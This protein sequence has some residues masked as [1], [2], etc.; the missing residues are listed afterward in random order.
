MVIGSA[1]QSGPGTSGHIADI[2][3]R[4]I[5]YFSP[6]CPHC[7]RLLPIWQTLY[8]FY[9]TS[10]PIQSVSF[11]ADIASPHSPFHVFYDFHF[12]RMNCQAFGDTCE[13]QKINGY[14]T[15]RLY[16]NGE[17]MQEYEGPHSIEGLSHFVEEKLEQIKPGSRP[18]EGVNLPTPG[19]SGVDRSLK[20]DKPL[21]KHND[22]HAGVA[23]GQK[24]NNQ[25]AAL[26]GGEDPPQSHVTT[27]D[28]GK[29]GNRKHSKPPPNP[30][31]T[32]LQL[33]AESFQRLL[34]MTQDAWFVKFYVPW[35]THCQAL[36]PI[37]DEVAKEMKGQLNI[38][39]VNCD[40]ESRLC[41]DA[42]VQAYPT[43]HY[44]RGDERVEYDGYR[45]LGDLL[46]FAQKA[47]DSD[48]K[49][50]DAS[51]FKAMEEDEEVIFLYFFD[52]A[53]TSEDFRAIER[54][55]LNLAGRA[56]IFKTDSE[57]LAQRFRISTWPRL[58]VSRD[59]K[60]TY[61]TALSPSDM[62]NY[63]QIFE[64]MKSVWLPLVPELSV[65]NA[66]DVFSD[67]FV[68]L[69]L[70]SRQRPDEFAASKRELKEAAVEWMDKQTHDFQLERQQ[71]R[72]DKQL[73][74]EEAEDRN[75]QRAVRQVKSQR[76]SITE[77]GFRKPVAF[78]WIDTDFWGRWLH[79]TYGFDAAEGERVIIN[80][81]EV[82]HARTSS[83]SPP[84]ARG[85][86][87]ARL[88]T[89]E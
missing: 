68:V 56:K 25:V 34:T 88:L 30:L 41:K 2:R 63:R 44:F 21:A 57:E 60:P 12:A 46:S 9:Y 89:C 53:T 18:P 52:H 59:G 42:Q 49:Y 73:R 13:E 72:D 70:L 75:D 79:N 77:E 80:D 78:A 24:H 65:Q 54:L 6:D 67:K 76:I 61:Y 31:G 71:M 23:A 50:A 10:T 40:L 15:L 37:W 14:P 7:K 66:V 45:R 4:F 17:L 55:T 33:T 48:I 36:A 35:C 27:S 62:R 64:W 43:I 51:Q 82:C 47:L 84:K 39:E 11:P 74:L 28:A 5:E 69:G 87:P 26:A 16:K 32:S 8:E 29:T 86:F 83:Q 22:T 58:L 1:L 38:G 3:S 81:E 19:A 20:P 85:S